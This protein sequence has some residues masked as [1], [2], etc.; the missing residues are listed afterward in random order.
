MLSTVI[1][2]VFATLALTVADGQSPRL[3]Q[4]PAADLVLFNGRF[5]TVDR[6]FSTHEAVAII[7]DRIMAVGNDE[8]WRND[9]RA[10]SRVRGGPS[11]VRY[12]GPAAY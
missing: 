12:W 9:S 1:R 5:I 11:L 8:A 10:E 7:G 4:P 3:P 6:D 2:S